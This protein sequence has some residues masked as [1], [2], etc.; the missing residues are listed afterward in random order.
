MSIERP[1]GIVWS[2]SIFAWC[3][4]Q[5]T[6]RDKALWSWKKSI[7]SFFLIY[8]FF[9]NR[10]LNNNISRRKFQHIFSEPRIFGKFIGVWGSLHEWGTS[11]PHTPGNFSH[12]RVQQEC[13][14]NFQLYS[15]QMR[16]LWRCSFVHETPFSSLEETN[17][18]D[19]QRKWCKENS[20]IQFN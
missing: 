2:R 13:F 20:R 14:K 15:S 11:Q 6:T 9:F 7:F 5:S 8:Y 4:L 3:I 16:V 1:F 19:R 17:I 12:V 18:C 10:R